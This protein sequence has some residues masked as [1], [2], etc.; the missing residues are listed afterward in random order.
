MR[1]EPRSA[2]GKTPPAIRDNAADKAVFIR[3]NDGKVPGPV[4]PDSS[5]MRA[6]GL[7]P[8]PGDFPET[9][10]LPFG[11]R[12]GVPSSLPARRIGPGTEAFT[13][14]A[15]SLGIPADPLDAALLSFSRYFSLPLEP[16]LLLKLRREVLSLKKPGDAGALGAAAAAGKGVELSPRGLEEY[17]AAIE[18]FVRDQGDAGGEKDRR[19]RAP[20]EGEYGGKAAPVPEGEPPEGEEL[21]ER[22]LR[23]EARLPL[24]DLLNRLPGREGR[25][26]MVFPFTWSSGGLAF[27]ISLRLVLDKP[28]YG[29]Q[30][31]LRLALDIQNDRRRWSFTLDK[32]GEAGAETRVSLSPPLPEAETESLRAELRDLLGALGGSLSLSLEPGASFEDSRNDTL[33]SV[34]EEV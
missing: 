4:L 16:G 24:L 1:L 11:P 12:E 33:L 15:L 10:K 14:L 23:N 28:R 9:G 6:E 21:R 19:N 2:A 22:I 13:R 20:P 32:P 18:G 8:D 34:N 5:R 25:R 17:A 31:V 3:R 27:R 29:S 7:E 26:W 30:R